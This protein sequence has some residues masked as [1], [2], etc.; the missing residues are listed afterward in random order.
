VLVVKI[1]QIGAGDVLILP[2]PRTASWTNRRAIVP[3][4]VSDTWPWPSE[5]SVDEVSLNR[6]T[7]SLR[8]WAM[9][10]GDLCGGGVAQS[11]YPRSQ[12]LGHGSRR[13]VRSG[14]VGPGPV[15]AGGICPRPGALPLGAGGGADERCFEVGDEVGGRLD[16]DREAHEVGRRGE[17][18]IGRRGVRHR[19][20]D[21]DQ[22]LYAAEAL[23]QLPDLRPPDERDRV[24]HARREERDPPA[25]ARHLA[26]GELVAR[27][28]GQ[29]GVEDGLDGRMP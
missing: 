29:A 23:G 9:A 7:P 18:R 15:P 28:A 6:F 22:A 3:P 27:V 25:E 10:V 12:R 17:G 8:D 24:L 16:P 13:P 26:R 20:R 11:F 14:L 2:K 21:L 4:S 1:D 5:T 19:G